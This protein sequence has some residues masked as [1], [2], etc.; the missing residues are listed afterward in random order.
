MA[1]IK[2]MTFLEAIQARRS[3]Y[4]I[5]NTSPI[6]DERIE[7]IIKIALLNAPSTFNSQT[8]RIIL[9]LKSEHE[10]FWDIALENVGAIADGPAVA[11]MEQ[12]IAGFRAGY[13][14]VS[15]MSTRNYPFSNAF[16][17]RPYSLK[18]LPL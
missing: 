15:L 1:A 5:T 6:P 3:I 14:T 13:G 12:R 8:T 16:I 2:Q 17:P 18:I 11:Y 10:K 7:E 4:S 9:L